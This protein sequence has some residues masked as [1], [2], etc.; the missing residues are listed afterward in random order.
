MR[1]PLFPRK[2]LSVLALVAIASLAI[3][4][5]SYAMGSGDKFVDAQTGLTY[6]VHKPS[7][8]LG[9]KLSTFQLIACAPGKEQWV[10]TKYG[11]GKKFIEIMETMAGDKCSNPGLSKSL[12]S[13]VINKVKAQVHVYCDP[14]KPAVFKKCSTA[15]IS[16]VG[17]YLMFTTKATKLLKGTEIQVQGIGGVTY[18]QLI[19]IAK[20]LKPL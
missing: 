1:L 13:I 17:G 7:Q 12:N 18:S 5:T 4:T 14:T 2:T 11:S 16:K 9:L 20:N 3:T 19:L 8:T 6:A 10:Y 15:D